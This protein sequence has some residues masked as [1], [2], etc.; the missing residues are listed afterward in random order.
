[1]QNPEY[2]PFYDPELDAPSGRKVGTTATPGTD[3]WRKELADYA[4]SS[5]AN[6]DDYAA[7]KAKSAGKG[8]RKQPNFK[9]LAKKYYEGRGMELEMRETSIWISGSPWPMKV[10][11]L[12]LFDGVI[13]SGGIER[14]GVQLCNKEGVTA[15]V[16]KMLKDKR[17]YSGNPRKNMLKWWQEGK[18]AVILYF[19]QPGGK[20][21][22]WKCDEREVTQ[23]D[24][25]RILAGKQIKT[26]GEY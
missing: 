20:G 19:Y 7:S 12:G 2:D 15:H 13:S 3:Q 1:M 25:D 24:L 9:P 11:Y 5:H 6:M 10:D 16:R 21:T 23:A 14:I 22:S 8:R 26:D 4:M 17:G 18:R